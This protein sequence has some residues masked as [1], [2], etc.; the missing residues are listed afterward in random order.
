MKTKRAYRSKYTWKTGS[1]SNLAVNQEKCEMGGYKE[2]LWNSRC[3][4]QLV[5]ETSNS[6]LSLQSKVV[7]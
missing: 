4:L 1:L 5:F 2:R 6:N 7:K 3:V